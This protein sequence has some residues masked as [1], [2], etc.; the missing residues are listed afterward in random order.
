MFVT[1]GLNGRYVGIISTMRRVGLIELS[2]S[3]QDLFQTP[4]GKRNNGIYLR[5]AR[6]TLL[7][8]QRT[9]LRL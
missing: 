1:S 7:D 3:S 4:P 5:F 9:E 2:R 8:R 6:Q